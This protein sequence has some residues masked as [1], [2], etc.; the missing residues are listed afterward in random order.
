MKIYESKLIYVFTKCRMYT[1]VVLYT[2]Y[3]QTNGLY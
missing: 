1:D 3:I 2:K